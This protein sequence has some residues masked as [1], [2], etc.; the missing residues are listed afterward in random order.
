MSASATLHGGNTVANNNNDM[1]SPRSTS[2]FADSPAVVTGNEAVN[3]NTIHNS[4]GNNVDVR[5]S[6]NNSTR[7]TQKDTS[8]MHSYCPPP[9]SQQQLLQYDIYPQ[10]TSNKA[11]VG[12]YHLEDSHLKNETVVRS[13]LLGVDLRVDPQ[14]SYTSFPGG[15]VGMKG[16][17]NK[18]VSES[19]L[20]KMLYAPHTYQQQLQERN[21]SVEDRDRGRDSVA[22][23]ESGSGYTN[24]NS[25]LDM[26]VPDVIRSLSIDSVGDEEIINPTIR[27]NN[28]SDNVSATGQIVSGSV[29]AVQERRVP[30]KEI[31]SNI[32]RNLKNNFPD[33]RYHC[34]L[35]TE[36]YLFRQQKKFKEA[37]MDGDDDLDLNETTNDNNCTTT[38]AMYDR[39][40]GGSGLRS[41]NDMAQRVQPSFGI[42]PVDEE[43]ITGY[44]ASLHDEPYLT[45]IRTMYPANQ[46][47]NVR[48]QSN[49]MSEHSF[50]NSNNN[51]QYS[52]NRALPQHL[53]SQFT[54]TTTTNMEIGIALGLGFDAGSYVDGTLFGFNAN[55]H[56]HENISNVQ[57]SSS[58]PRYGDGHLCDY[59]SGNMGSANLGGYYCNDPTVQQQ[60]YQ[61]QQ[62]QQY[63]LQ[64]LNH[65]QLS[66]LHG[67]APVETVSDEIFLTSSAALLTDSHVVDS[68]MY[69]MG[70]PYARCGYGL[71]S[72]PLV[73]V[74]HYDTNSMFV[75]GNVSSSNPIA[76]SRMSNHQ[77]VHSMSG[78]DTGYGLV[79]RADSGYSANSKVVGSGVS[80]GGSGGDRRS[81]GLISHP[82]ITSSNNNR[83]S[84]CGSINSNTM[85][86]RLDV[87]RSN[88]SLSYY[89]NDMTTNNQ[90]LS[91]NNNTNSNNIMRSH[92]YSFPCEWNTSEGSS[93]YDPASESVGFDGSG[94][95]RGGSGVLDVKDPMEL[96][97]SLSTGD[98]I[99]GDGGGNGMYSSGVMPTI[100]VDNGTLESGYVPGY[101]PGYVSYSYERESHATV[102]NDRANQK[103]NN[104]NL[105][106]NLNKNGSQGWDTNANIT[107]TTTTTSNSDMNQYRTAGGTPPNQSMYGHANPW[108][109]HHDYMR[110]AVPWGK[111]GC[112]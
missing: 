72:Y 55:S 9:Q 62:Q 84:L 86:T 65:Q 80:G 4:N 26:V 70:L 59:Y 54:A 25:P 78:Y 8:N 30:R 28:A 7:G 2:L 50:N 16:N 103:Q 75:S 49:H 44:A 6:Y 106:M 83:S 19:L 96:S 107:T 109:L 41:I 33:F 99:W 108:S 17:S 73:Q 43:I 93:A 11:T 92:S 110:A 105:S 60:P 102:R 27:C 98:T 34:D 90:I 14:P 104:N 46:L 69:K 85:D 52:N 97:W 18:T 61:Q 51:M 88:N 48:T 74:N 66:H 89:E 47:S 31:P 20:T 32:A 76:C 63:Y 101:V 40:M 12:Q 37:P 24:E 23:G 5:G 87:M 29:A 58:M 45:Q 56:M 38:D 71:E 35:L 3:D 94:W 81:N 10:R 39:N 112:K 57:R 111:V 77:D 15:G 64:Q 42:L 67:A 36:A 53:P 95:N 21:S 79:G 22:V 82:T 91:T 13:A 100:W 68:D 1:T